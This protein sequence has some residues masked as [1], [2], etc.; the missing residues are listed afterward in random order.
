VNSL[1]TATIAG[2]I[3][4]CKNDIKPNITFSGSAGAPPYTFTYTINSGTNQTISSIGSDSIVT[5]AVPTNTAG[6][7]IYNLL[8]VHDASPT[9][10]SQ[11]QNGTATVTVNPLPTAS[12]SG[13]AS[14][15]KDATAPNITFTGAGSTAPYTFTYSINGGTNQTISTITGNSVTSSVSTATAGTYIYSLISIKDASATICSQI[16]T[17]SATVT[18]NPKP[19]VSFTA[20]DTA[21][22]EGLCINFFDLSSIATGHNA[23]WLWNFGDG[24]SGSE[25]NHCYTN[26]SVYSTHYFN[27]TLTVTS[28][29]G[30]VNS[31]IKNNYI[32]VYPKPNA[33]F[34]AMPDTTTIMD[35]VISILNLSAGATFSFW[36]FGDK[37]TSSIYNPVSHTYADTGKYTITLVTSTQYG[38]KDTSKQI[39][40]IEPD[41]AFFIPS[42]FTPNDDGINDTFTGKGVFISNYQMMIFDRWG[43]L[44]FFTNDI[45]KPWDGKANYGTEIAQ[46]DV[47]VYTIKLADINRKVHNYKGIVKLLR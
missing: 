43:N 12:I 37:D 47:Y 23:L 20:N 24:H 3:A 31:L 16:Q 4:V 19:I 28:D 35:P 1:P 11:T 45:N 27:V 44:I 46:A 22:C 13:T 33:S 26:G 8:S 9:A 42:A 15:C 39:V 14:V 21:G 25:P 17:G 6:I 30:C 5:I 32:T 29:S 18:V 40:I 38:C 34:K 36:N 7:F 10:C 41:F 2:A